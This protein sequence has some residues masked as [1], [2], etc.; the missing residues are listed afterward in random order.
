MLDLDGH[1][2]DR[3]Q[4]AMKGYRR[5]AVRNEQSY[6]VSEMRYATG[7]QPPYKNCGPAT[8]STSQIEEHC[9]TP[10]YGAAD[11]LVVV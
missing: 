1:K 7:L 4:T 8:G 3:D 5:F 9:T 11:T 6:Q 10:F 2:R